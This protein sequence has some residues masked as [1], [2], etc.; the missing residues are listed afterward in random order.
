MTSESRR[1]RRDARRGA[2]EAALR[3]IAGALGAVVI[4][5]SLVGSVA[6]AQSNAPFVVGNYPVEATAENAVAAKERAMAEGQSAAFRYL[7]KRLVESKSYKRLP[8]LDAAAVDNL[9][10]GVSVRAEQNSRK[11]YIAT[12][13]YAFKPTAVRQ[14]LDSYGLPYTDRQAGQLVVVPVVVVAPGDSGTPPKKL[15]GMPVAAAEKAWQAAWKGLDLEHALT[16]IK[17]SGPGASATTDTY[18]AISAG[19]LAAVGVISGEVAAQRLVVA[20]VE[21]AENG[22]VAVTLAGNDWVGPLFLQRRYK[23]YYND[24]GYTSEFATLI[25]LGVLEGRWKANVGGADVAASAQSQFGDNPDAVIGEPVRMTA[26]F[27]GM[28]AFREIRTILLETPGVERLKIGALTSSSAMIEV[29]FVGGAPALA[30]A[31]A[32][33][34]LALADNDGILILRAD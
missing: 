26:Q 28:P 7:L 5:G 10:D 25:A 2:I 20:L 8:R 1:P 4:G 31:L 23:L 9:I 17:L 22:Q 14:L 27:E 29:A 13:D 21:P 18:Q 15:F 6:V 24:F 3:V 34:G 19:D 16:P 33:Q 12:L 11:E 32:A 30:S